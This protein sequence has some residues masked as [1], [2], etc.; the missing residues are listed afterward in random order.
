MCFL[1][2]KPC[3]TSRTWSITSLSLICSLP[4]RWAS[5]AWV[6]GVGAFP[7]HLVQVQL[8]GCMWAGPCLLGISF[9]DQL[10]AVLFP[11]AWQET[12]YVMLSRGSES[13]SGIPLLTMSCWPPQQVV[14]VCSVSL[15]LS[16]WELVPHFIVLGTS[17]LPQGG[18]YSN[19]MHLAGVGRHSTLLRA[20]TP[21]P[22]G[23][24]LILAFPAWAWCQ[25]ES[26]R[27]WEV[28][29][30]SVHRAAATFQA[31]KCGYARQH[32]TGCGSR[33]GNYLFLFY[34]ILK[35]DLHS[36]AIRCFEGNNFVCPNLCCCFRKMIVLLINSW[37]KTL[38][39]SGAQ[40]WWWGLKQSVAQNHVHSGAFA[41][42]NDSPVFNFVFTLPRSVLSS[43]C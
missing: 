26:K 34:F 36:N 37:Y 7:W 42:I 33:E 20:M 12:V 41:W 35:T 27:S 17:L 43:G 14:F 8:E 5:W 19:E 4:S 9:R 16:R 1:L 3:K 23:C 22:E 13:C 25:E 39:C 40:N 31:C 21:F 10:T 18:A 6:T 29:L 11:T 32:Q 24:T 38:F 30:R 28:G 15:W 2:R